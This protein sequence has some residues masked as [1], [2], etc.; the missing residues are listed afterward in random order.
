MPSFPS[1]SFSQAVL[2]ISNANSGRNKVK[3][4]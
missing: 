4:F 2:Q 3:N 1:R